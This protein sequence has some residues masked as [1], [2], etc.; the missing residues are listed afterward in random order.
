MLLADEE[1]AEAFRGRSMEATVIYVDAWGAWVSGLAPIPGDDGSV[2][3]LVS[4]DVSVTGSADGSS[5]RSDVTETFTAL[6][7]SAATR[8]TRM[9]IDAVMDSLTGL[10][11][12][13]YLHERVSEE[14][15]L[16]AAKGSEL[17]ILFVDVDRFK[18]VN[19]QFGHSAGDE[20][21]RTVAQL[22]VSCVRRI[23]VAARYGGDEFAV[24]LIGAGR[25]EASEVAERI[26]T[27]VES[28]RLVGPVG[29]VTVSVG[30]ATYPGH[31]GTKAELL[32]K[33]DWAMYVAKRSGRNR[34]AIFGE[35]EGR[36]L[37]PAGD[38][39][40][41]GYLAAMAQLAERRALYLPEHTEAVTQLAEAVA[42][43]MGLGPAAAA[44]VAEAAR[45]R[46]IGQLPVADDVLRKT[47][48]LTAGEWESIRAH[49][50][51]GC[52]M[53]KELTGSTALAEAVLHHHERYDG[54]GYPDELAAAQIPLSA[55]IVA[56]AS[57]FG[58]MLADRP[59]RQ[60]LQT[61]EARAELRRCAG[62]QLDPDVVDALLRVAAGGIGLCQDA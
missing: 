9:E 1:Q 53:L 24:A 60:R 44:G 4:A 35:D 57:V 56:A 7:H 55:R 51:A 32:E 33:A 15:G 16:A 34:C 18:S 38:A 3:A 2:A 17:S 19:D 50:R 11:N 43:Q 6:T 27:A 42:L 31:A 54:C 29:H 25:E 41:T 13:R 58:A 22:V 12:H 59:Y 36:T 30:V 23:D 49:P 62:S 48:P 26:R 39:E 40:L 61:D 52:R 45:L 28:A 14:L 37:A 47:E 21:L 5:L 46:D 8:L 20:I 10:H